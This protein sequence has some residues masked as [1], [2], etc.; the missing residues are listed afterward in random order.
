MKVRPDRNNI[1]LFSSSLVP[2]GG[3]V[4][5][6]SAERPTVGQFVVVSTLMF[7]F[8][9][10]SMSGYLSNM[11]DLAPRH[12][13]ALMGISNTVATLPGVF[14]NVLAGMLLESTGSYAWTFA[15]PVVLAIAGLMAFF[16]Y[17]KA[18]VVVD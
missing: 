12:T 11:L 17:G 10:F 9:G 18:H 5:L 3:L 13:G 8:A 16:A 6:V 1:V 15:I 2:A 14:G 7:F 4:L